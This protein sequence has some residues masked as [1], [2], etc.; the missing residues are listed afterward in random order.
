MTISIGIWEGPIKVSLSSVTIRYKDTTLGYSQSLDILKEQPTFCTFRGAHYGQ[1]SRQRDN[2]EIRDL[3]GLEQTIIY[4]Y[5]FIVSVSS[6]VS[7]SKM[8][9]ISGQT[10]RQTH[11]YVHLDNVRID[12]PLF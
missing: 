10:N 1:M 8:V 11:P 3:Q 4:S 2:N 9:V 12:S 5:P 6:Y 7:C